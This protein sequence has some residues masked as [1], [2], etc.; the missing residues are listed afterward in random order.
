MTSSGKARVGQVRTLE[1][2]DLLI[3]IEKESA[4]PVKMELKSK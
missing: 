3:W 4:V 1:G 2:T